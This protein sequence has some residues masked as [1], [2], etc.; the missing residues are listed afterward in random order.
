M[1]EYTLVADKSGEVRMEPEEKL[2]RYREIAEQ[3]ASVME[4][5]EDLLA[6]MASVVCLLHNAFPYYYWTGFY[7]R[8]A[9]D[10]LLVGPYQG[11]LGCLRIPFS[12][13][14]CGTAARERRTVIVEDVNAFPGHIACDAG[15]LSEIVVPVFD[16]AGELT[17]VLDVDSS[18]P[19]AFDE[20]DREQ[21]EAIV[22]LLREKRS[23]PVV[24]T[25]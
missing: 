8:V 17:G 13:G 19:A 4:D 7:R 18:A 6:C 10:E 16:A 21:L 1:A 3:L 20:M 15:S 22:A 9:P 23:L 14:V 2:A 25:S 5:E 11:T 24:W 12:R